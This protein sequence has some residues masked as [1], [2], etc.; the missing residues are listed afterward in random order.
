MKI[1]ALWENWILDP[2]F[3]R[4]VLC[5]WAKKAYGVLFLIKI[6]YRWNTEQV[7]D[8]KLSQVSPSYKTIE[9]KKDILERRKH[10]LIKFCQE[11]TIEWK[12]LLLAVRPMLINIFRFELKRLNNYLDTGDS[13]VKYSIREG[14]KVLAS[15]AAC[16]PESRK[17]KKSK[18]WN[19]LR[20][21]VSS[22]RRGHAN[23]LCIVPILVY[24]FRLEYI[25]RYQSD[26]IYTPSYGV[27]FR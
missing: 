22:L 16:S 27:Y 19:A 12:T 11:F 7:K 4:P 14:S 24:V 15:L 1:D 18:M 17:S 3:T 6:N 21:C 2:W 23:L 5:L 20:F 9:A 26:H 25:F 8:S 13:K 10:K